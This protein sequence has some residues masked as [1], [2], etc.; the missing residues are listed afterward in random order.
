MA[1]PEI[2]QLKELMRQ[3]IALSQENNHM[4][5]SMRNAGRLKSIVW[6]VLILISI[7]LTYWSYA[8]YIQPRIGTIENFYRTTVVPLQGAQSGFTNFIKNFGQ[9]A[10]TTTA[11]H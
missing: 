3:N 2:E 5:R 7:A 8:I 9:P 10:A 11:A 1:D 4:L 6:W